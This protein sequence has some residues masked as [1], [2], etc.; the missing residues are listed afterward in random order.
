MLNDTQGFCN[1]TKFKARHLGGS[2][3]TGLVT[4]DVGRTSP[5]IAARSFKSGKQRPHTKAP[6]STGTG[7]RFVSK[8]ST[9][10]ELR[11]TLEIRDFY[12]LLLP[13]MT[14]LAFSS[15]VEPLRIA[16][17]LT[18]RCLYRWHL[19]SEDGCPV[20]CSNGVLMGGG[21]RW[22]YGD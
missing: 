20:R 2:M 9:L 22:A 17:Q 6:N 10:F 5:V 4:I 8:V 21:G 1:I 12:F 16:N 15:A 13:Q 19:I 7:D 11:H 3:T 18:G 14:M